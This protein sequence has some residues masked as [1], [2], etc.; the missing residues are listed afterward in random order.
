MITAV[1]TS[2]NHLGANYARFRP[3]RLEGRRKRL[4]EAFASV[5]GEAIARKVNLF[6]HAGDLF[7]RP[8][9]RNDE[10]RFVASQLRRLQEAQIPV[11][12]IAG[13]HDCPRSYG[14][15]GGVVPQEEADILGAITLIRA[16]D[17]LH[18]VDLNIQGQRIRVWGMSTDFNRPTDVCPLEGLELKREDPDIL[19]LV[20][21]HYGVEG[22]IMPT[23]SEP[24]L[25]RANLDRLE[26]DAICVGHLHQRFQ[27]KTINGALLVNPGSTERIDF[28]EEGHRCSFTLLRCGAGNTIAE[29]IPLTMQPMRTLEINLELPVT[30][31]G[32]EQVE[33]AT[34]VEGSHAKAQGLM[35]E[36]RDKLRAASHSDQLLRVRLV[37]RMPRNVF[38]QMDFPELQKVGIQSNF[39]CQF[40]TEKMVIYDPDSELP[41]G[42]GVSFDV[43]QE[44]ANIANG[45]IGN[46]QDNPNETALYRLAYEKVRER[47]DLVTKGAR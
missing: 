37:G 32:M 15:G 7:D 30:E 17:A 46:H 47:Y 19:Q 9:P 3:E 28:G 23:E 45:L 26:A 41:L 36:Y 25:S 42:Y 43:A 8:E 2:D 38:H 21:L 20:L 14:Y 33:S 35:A 5:V 31:Q 27:T 16:N 13:N 6:L 39:H 24:V 40:D 10:R 22:W 34:T 18:S 1:L 11:I 44:L 29:E 4:R 12:A